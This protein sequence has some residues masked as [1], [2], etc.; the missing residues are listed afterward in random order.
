MHRD[1]HAGD[2]EYHYVLETNEYCYHL[3]LS[4]RSVE[5]SLTGKEVRSSA[6]HL[7]TRETETIPMSTKVIV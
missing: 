6:E 1:D 5:F 3:I 2:N 7:A 4:P